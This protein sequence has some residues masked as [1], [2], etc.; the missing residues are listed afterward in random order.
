MKIAVL[1]ALL[2][3][4]GCSIFQGVYDY[5]ARNACRDLPTIDERLA[6]ERAA[7]DAAR[8]RRQDKFSSKT[9]IE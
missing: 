5:E 9:E 7:D 6:C 2:G 1:I 8:E 4:S 3:L